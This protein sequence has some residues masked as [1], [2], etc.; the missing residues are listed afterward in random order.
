MKKKFF[1]ARYL[2]ALMLVL[3]LAAGCTL[4]G[5]KK[6]EED[7]EK[8]AVQ[9]KNIEDKKDNGTADINETK[10]ED[11]NENDEADET[12]D[13]TTKADKTSDWKLISGDINDTCSSPTY[14][15]E[16]QISGWYVYDY[17]YVE[18]EWLLQISAEDTDKIPVAEVYGEKSYSEWIK[19]PQ[20]VLDGV[21]P[22]LEKELKNASSEKPK[23]ITVKGFKAYCEG[24]PQL[25][26][27][28]F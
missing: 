17:S 7:K 21:T 28:G 18:K 1:Q 10:E 5:E 6:K 22:E 16:A 12:E 27:N 15:G 9:E 3:L 24:A 8:D 25:S 11:V 13:K 19:K 26:L 14:S 2:L 4:G 23:T 20:F